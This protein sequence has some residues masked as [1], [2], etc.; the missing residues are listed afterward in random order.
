MLRIFGTQLRTKRQF[1]SQVKEYKVNL[2]MCRYELFKMHDSETASD[3]FMLCTNIINGI[4]ELVGIS[5]N[6][7]LI[8]KILRSLPKDWEPKVTAIIEDLSKLAVNQLI[9]FLVTH[10]MINSNED[11]KKK[12]KKGLALNAHPDG[13]DD[14]F[15]NED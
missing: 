8:S 15:N 11:E 6:V 12:K 3:M 13:D 4:K 14:N 2:V 10:E 7:E 9:G 1:T 5:P